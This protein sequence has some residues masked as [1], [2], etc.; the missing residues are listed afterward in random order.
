MGV[1]SCGWF[2]GRFQR[3][4]RLLHLQHSGEW[5]SRRLT[6]VISSLTAPQ[7]STGSVVYALETTG[8]GGVASFTTEEARDQNV[9][10]GNNPNG[11][12]ACVGKLGAIV[13]APE[14]FSSTG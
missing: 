11:T 9:Y 10:Q 14:C 2:R 5:L 12:R 13:D 1:R 6:V 4:A 7:D 8:H 3:D